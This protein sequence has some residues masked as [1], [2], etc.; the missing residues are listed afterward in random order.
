MKILIAI[1]GSVS[2]QAAVAEVAERPWPPQSEVRLLTVDAP[3]DPGLLQCSPPTLFEQVVAQQRAESNKRL[4]EAA[5]ILAKEAPD[6]KVSTALREGWPKEV[7][8]AEAED[9]GANLIVIGSHGTGPIRRFFLGSVSLYVAQNAPC[10]VQ[11]V[12]P[13]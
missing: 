10:S 1:D 9:W 4:R 13:R 12:R 6:L 5:A 3:V 7:I 11:I 8:V 2:S